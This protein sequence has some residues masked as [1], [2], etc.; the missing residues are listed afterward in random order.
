MIKGH[1]GPTIKAEFIYKKFSK[2][3][4]RQRERHVDNEYLIMGQIK[5]NATAFKGLSATLIVAKAMAKRNS[6]LKS[7]QEEKDDQEALQGTLALIK[8][9]AVHRS[10]EIISRI[11]QENFLVVEKQRMNFSRAKATKFYSHLKG[12]PNHEQMINYIISGE[13]VALCLA[14]KD[15][16]NRWRRLMGPTKPSEARLLAPDSI[17][18]QFGDDDNDL[19]NAVH[20]SDSPESSE[21]EIEII[22]PHILQ[23]E[24]QTEVNRTVMLQDNTDSKEYLVKYVCPTLLR[25][26][27]EMNETRPKSPVAWLADWLKENNPYKK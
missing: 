11:A 16:I 19:Y 2:V 18:A 1:E 22:F 10:A 27:S 9:D 21:R 7:N 20:G 4:H 12:Q 8:P 26:L 13:V 24:A 6:F 17:R 23:G 15:G 25:G 14:R 5:T 3:V